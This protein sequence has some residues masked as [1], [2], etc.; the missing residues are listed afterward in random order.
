YGTPHQH[1]DDHSD[2]ETR[3]DDHWESERNLGIAAQ[4]RAAVEKLMAVWTAAGSGRVLEAIEQRE[5]P[6]PDPEPGQ[7]WWLGQ[8]EAEEQSS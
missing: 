2:G 6:L 1:D 7:V 3:D 5:H 4:G 8:D